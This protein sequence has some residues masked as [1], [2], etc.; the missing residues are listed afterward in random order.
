MACISISAAL[1]AVGVY[2][3]QTWLEQWD[4]NRHVED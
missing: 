3:L 1:A 4:H 2:D